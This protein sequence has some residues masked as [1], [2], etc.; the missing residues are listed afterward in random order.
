ML[1]QRGEWNEVRTTTGRIRGDR[2]SKENTPERYPRGVA[3][4]NARV[5]LR[6]K[7]FGR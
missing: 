3:V 4:K 6:L 1:K 2:V 7:V 5:K